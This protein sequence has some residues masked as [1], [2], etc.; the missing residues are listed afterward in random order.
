MQIEIDGKNINYEVQGEG[1]PVVILHGWLASL[2]TMKP[3]VNILKENFKVYNIDIIGFGKSEIQDEPYNTNDYGDFLEKF[4]KKLNIEN[5]ILIGHS[6]GGRTIINCVG[7]KLID[8]K[9]IILIDSAGIKPVR[10]MFYYIKLKI[11]K[12][13]KYIISKLPNSKAI[14]EKILKKVASED[15][16][17]SPEVLRKTMA[18]ILDEDQSENL[19]NIQAPTLLVWGANDTATPIRDAKI[20][21]ELIPNA[22][23][24]TY[25]NSGHFSFLENIGNFG[26]VIKEFLKNEL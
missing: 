16:K 20:M 7:R 8:P 10:T 23:L 6:H 2:E 26:I 12:F 1:Y 9:K 19:K 5:P 14:N 15:Y 24:V 4:I 13:G 3:I 18:I 25:P 17:N 11:F 21:E 22:G